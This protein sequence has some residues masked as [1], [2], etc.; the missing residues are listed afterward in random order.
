[1]ELMPKANPELLD[2]G[3]MMLVVG[4]YEALAAARREAQRRGIDVAEVVA[5]AVHRFVVGAD[6]RELLEEFRRQ[7]AADAGALSEDEAT[8]IAAEEL[9]ALRSERR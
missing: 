9:A 1:M 5:E 8:R 6:L 3:L 4:H 7:D 2:R